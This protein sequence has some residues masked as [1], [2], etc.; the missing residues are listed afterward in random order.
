[1]NNN[2]NRMKQRAFILIAAALLVGAGG[3]AQTYNVLTDK[4]I[5]RWTGSKPGKTHSGIINLKEGSFTIRD[6]RF[7]DGYF[8]I[9]MNSIAY[10][11]G[12]DPSR[13]AR[14]VTHLKSDDFFS[15]EKYPEA[16]LKITAST[17]FK[18]D[19]AEVTADLTIKGTTHPVTFEA[20]RIGGIYQA[21]VTFDRS[22]YDVRYGS[23]K[24]FDNLGNAAIDNMIPVMVTLVARKVESGS[25]DA[26]MQGGVRTSR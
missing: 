2:G 19:A 5:L 8:V 20:R 25:K 14:L 4:S 1:M 17:P 9:D 6:N 24:F 7:A 26:T 18:R 21:T 16:T 22:L 12:T 10:G 11:D 23:D 13:G 15:V 3:F